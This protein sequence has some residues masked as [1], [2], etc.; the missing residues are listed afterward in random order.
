M[1]RISNRKIKHA[2]KDI[3]GK[4]RQVKKEPAYDEARKKHGG[5]LTRVKKIALK[6]KEDSDRQELRK[7]L[8]E[9][10]DEMESL[11]PPVKFG[12]FTPAWV[13]TGKLLEDMSEP[14]KN[15]NAPPPAADDQ[16][17]PKPDSIPPRPEGFSAKAH[18]TLW[19]AALTFRNEPF[20]TGELAS[21]TAQAGSNDGGVSETRARLWCKKMEPRYLTH[22]GKEKKASKYQLKEE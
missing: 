16:K 2:L 6:F 20:T 10:E 19:V 11:V 8:E 15:T 9:I 22:N 17:P 1:E 21:K 5:F 13:A 12:I 7:Q 18:K 4:L 14:A 3:E